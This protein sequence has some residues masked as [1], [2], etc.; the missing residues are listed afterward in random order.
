[1]EKKKADAKRE[2][3][4]AKAEQRA[5]DVCQRRLNRAELE[6]MR[7]GEEI[8]GLRNTAHNAAAQL[9]SEQRVA[10]RE[11]AAA[12]ALAAEL[13]ALVGTV[14]QEKKLVGGRAGWQM[15]GMG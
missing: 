11:A 5:R 15:G 9:G 8:P 6:A 13:S 10:A 2:A 12:A 3:E 4:A 1:M 7:L 14:A